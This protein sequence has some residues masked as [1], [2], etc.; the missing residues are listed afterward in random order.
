MAEAMAVGTPVIAT[1]Y[2]GN[3]SFMSED[4]ALLVDFTEV[5][6]GPGSYYPAN[7]H[8]AEPDL[9]H[10]ATLMRSIVE[11][12]SQRARLSAAGIAEIQRHSAESAGAI[13]AERLRRVFDD[14]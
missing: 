2:S 14:H 10:A 3:L 8:W 6:I 7:G 11:D 13:M 12:E 4:S 5:T 9:D 1:G